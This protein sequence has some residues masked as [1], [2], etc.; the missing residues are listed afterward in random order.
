[1]GLA[2]GEAVSCKDPQSLYFIT[3][4]A[5]TFVKIGI[6]RNPQCRLYDLQAG[7]PIPLEFALILEF[8]GDGAS[9]LEDALHQHFAAHWLHRE[10]FAYADPIKEYAA[11]WLRGEKPFVPQPPYKCSQALGEYGERLTKAEFLAVLRS[12]AAA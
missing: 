12:E 2:G 7:C 6:S 1:L 3:D 8:N 11:S 9:T 10:W 5:K 4:E